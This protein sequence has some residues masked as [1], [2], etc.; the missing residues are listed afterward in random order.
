MESDLQEAPAAS[1]QARGTMA[2]ALAEALEQQAATSEILRVISSSPADIQPVF[3]AIA[4]SAVH[5]CHGQFCAVFR[6]EDDL[7]QV[8]GLHGMSAEGERAYRQGFPLKAGPGSA[9][10]RAILDQCVVHIPDIKADLD[11]RLPGMA[12]MKFRSVLGVP[13]VRDGVVIGGI[14]VGRSIAGPF[15][16]DRIQL[17]RTFADQGAIAIALFRDVAITT[18][19]QLATQFV[20]EFRPAG[21]SIYREGDAGDKFFIIV[22]GTV[23]VTTRNAGDQSIRLAALQDGDY[24]GEGE[25]ISRGRRTTTVT[26][27]TPCLVLALRAEHFH[28][29]VNQ[30]SL[31]NKV[32]TQMALGRSLSTICSVGRR[33]RSHAVWQG[34]V[35]NAWI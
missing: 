15:T 31:L 33:R 13:M 5:L 1:D 29:M 27:T 2:A 4:R 16:E 34:L 23:S 30:L 8:A 11:Y 12:E 10:G 9:I 6:L 22:R 19:D 20:S 17:L 28:A 21:E 25:M 35:P 24:F 26:A 3:D 18:L 14:A 7:I 32:V